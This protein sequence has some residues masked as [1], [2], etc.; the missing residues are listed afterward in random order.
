MN[1]APADRREESY[2]V[3]GMKRRVPRG[4]LAVTRRDQGRAEFAKLRARLGTMGE[5]V[6]DYG[7]VA[8]LHRLFAGAGSFLQSAEVEHFNQHGLAHQ[9]TRIYRNTASASPAAGASLY[10]VP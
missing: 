4:E 7:A 8:Q 6:L 9:F 5:Q 2:F 3:A 10:S 1:S